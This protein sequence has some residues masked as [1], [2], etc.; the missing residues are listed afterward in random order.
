M[1]NVAALELR[2]GRVYIHDT[3]LVSLAT[4]SD[5]ENRCEWELPSFLLQ[6]LDQ[7][8]L[9]NGQSLSLAG[10]SATGAFDMSVVGAQM[11]GFR[12][13]PSHLR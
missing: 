11:P 8:G 6:N 4:F 9:H 12:P 5:G 3:M 13:R 10:S 7:I 1:Y 2:G